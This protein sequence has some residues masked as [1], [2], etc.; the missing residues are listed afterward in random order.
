MG[1][2]PISTG[3][4]ARTAAAGSGY[5]ELLVTLAASGREANATAW[6]PSISLSRRRMQ[7]DSARD[8]ASVHFRASNTRTDVRAAGGVCRRRQPAGLVHLHVPLRACQ[9]CARVVAV[10]AVVNALQN[11]ISITADVT[12]HEVDWLQ[13]PRPCHGQQHAVIRN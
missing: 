13:Q 2:E 7:R 1:P 12:E 3:P 8:A 6:R 11:S 4:V 10:V 9:V 5:S